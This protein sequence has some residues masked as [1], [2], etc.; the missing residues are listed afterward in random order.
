[1]FKERKEK[2]NSK[3]SYKYKILIVGVPE[4]K[5]KK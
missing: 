5:R 3:F 1:M 2:P 4:C